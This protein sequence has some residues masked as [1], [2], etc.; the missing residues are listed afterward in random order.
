MNQFLSQKFRFYLFISILLVVVVH[1][2]NLNESYLQ[3][4]TII[5][6]PIRFTTFIEYWLANGLFRFVVPLLFLISGYLLSYGDSVPYSIRINKK[7][8]TLVIPYL[9]WSAF[10]MTITYYLQL[11]PNT[12]QSVLAT[13]LDQLGDSRPYHLLSWGGLVLRWTLFPI[14][15]QLWF[16]RCLFVYNVASPLIIK[17][18]SVSPKIWF[19]ICTFLWMTTFGMHFIE[20]EGLLF[21]SLG[22]YIHK[23]GFNVET[24]NQYLQP[25]YWLIVLL[26]ASLSK[27]VLAF[28]LKGGVESYLILSILYKLTVAAA[29]IV[30]WFG[31]NDVV[32]YFMKRKWFYSISSY[33]FI[34]YALHVPLINY[35]SSYVFSHLKHFAFFRLTAFVCIPLIIISFSIIVG[36]IFRKVAPKLY[37]ICTGGRG[38]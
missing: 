31:G 10:A 34:V 28:Y 30:V 9:I 38:F 16:I 18:L 5:N 25:K 15:F 24:P 14:A 3:P 27:T 19:S 12:S 2:Y 1:G 17:A 8:K 29:L 26:G 22:I 33:S 32:Q 13:H 11:Y 20:G 7:I 21:F 35:F 37:G 4:F 6:E 36:I 23:I